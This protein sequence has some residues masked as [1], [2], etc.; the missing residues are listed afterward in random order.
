MYGSGRYGL[1]G[2][3]LGHSYSSQ[4][5][6][7]LADYEFKLYET[8]PEELGTF[9]RTTDLSGMNVTIPYKKAVMEYCVELSETARKMG[10]CNTLV[11]EADGWH[12][13]N[14]DYY[15][16][17]ALVE[18]AG[19]EI[20]NRKVLVLGSGGASNTVCRA[21]EDMGARALIVISRSGEN[22]YTNLDRHADAEIIVNATPVGMFPYNGQAPLELKLFPRLEGVVD[23]IYNPART[24]LLLEA[25]R[26]G[27]KNADGL[28]MLTAQA[29]KAAEIYT[30]RSIPESENDRVTNILRAQMNNIILIGMPGC[31]KSEVGRRIAERTGRK[32]IDADQAIEE[33]AGCRPIPEIFRQDGEEGFRKLETSVLAELGKQSGTVIATGGGCITREENYPLLHQ[34]GILVWLQ[35]DISKLPIHGRPISQTN[36]LDKLYAARKDSYERFS[37]VCIDNNGAIEDTVDAVIAAVNAELAE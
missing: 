7:M 25:E 18:H 13:H 16:F 22:N 17:F 35:R 37:D 36:P 26:L 11:R 29:K 6:N 30:G 8:E 32:F 10:C 1:L 34:N 31:G 19:I 23:L 4:L 12:G 9:L 21:V 2:R 15:G 27:I 24:E 5:H 20:R 28:Y 3:K 33:S 14:T